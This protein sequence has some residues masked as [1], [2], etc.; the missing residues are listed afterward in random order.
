MKMTLMKSHLC[1]VTFASMLRLVTSLTIKF[2]YFAQSWQF[3]Y[4]YKISDLYL[5]NNKSVFWNDTHAHTEMV[6]R[7]ICHQ[8]QKT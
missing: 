7:F 2:R 3:I 5:T 6:A 1:G 8:Q 4:D